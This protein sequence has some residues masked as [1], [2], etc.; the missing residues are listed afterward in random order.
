MWEGQTVLTTDLIWL[1]I[2]SAEEDVR[3]SNTFFIPLITKDLAQ[4]YP[5]PFEARLFIEYT[6]ICGYLRLLS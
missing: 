3:D 2:I 4:F 6:L 5:L 1:M